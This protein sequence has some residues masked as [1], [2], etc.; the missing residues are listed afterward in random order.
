[1]GEPRQQAGDQRL[2]PGQAVGALLAML[3][4]GGGEQDGDHL[5]EPGIC[6]L[7]NSGNSGNS[8]N[9][10][11][12]LSLGISFHQFHLFCLGLHLLFSPKQG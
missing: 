3:A 4:G 2:L 11:F 6:T 9:S 1:M 10:F 7:I 8:G 5:L 12:F